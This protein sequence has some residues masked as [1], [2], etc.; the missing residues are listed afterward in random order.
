MRKS[1]LSFSVFLIFL[2]SGA[3]LGQEQI[4]AT[5][6][7]LATHGFEE[8]KGQVRYQDPMYNQE[9]RYILRDKGLTLFFHKQG[10]TYQWQSVEFEEGPGPF[11]HAK[12]KVRKPKST[13]TYRVDQIWESSSTSTE[14]I[15]E[16]PLAG[17]TL[18]NQE[19]GTLKASHYSK[20]VYHNIYPN[21]DIEYYIKDNR[22]KYDVVVK[23]GAD[24]NLV[25]FHYEGGVDPTLVNGKIRIETPLGYLEEQQPVTY[26]KSGR[27]LSSQYSRQNEHFGFSVPEGNQELAYTIDPDLIWGTYYGGTLEEITSDVVV[28]ASGNVYLAGTTGSNT[29]IAISGHQTTYNGAYDAY[30]VKFNSAGVRQWGTY[31]GGTGEEAAY[32]LSVDGTGNIYLSGYTNSASGISQTGGHQTI[33]GGGYDAF[34]VKFNTSGTRVWATYYGGTADDFPFN[35]TCDASG[36]VYVA[37]RASSTTAIASGGHQNT[38]GGLADAFLVKFNSSGVRQFATYYGGTGDDYGLDCE[39]DASG[40][41]FLSGQTFSTNAIST[42]GSHQTA[43]GGNRDGFLVKFNSA[44]VRQF[45]TYYGGTGADFLYAS[46]LDPGGNIIISG[47]TESTTG[48]ASGGHQITLLGTYDAFVVKFNTSG[49]RQ[50]GTY[51]GNTGSDFAA[52]YRCIATDVNSNIFL[53]G[54]TTSTTGI[55]SGGSFTTLAGGSDSYLVKFNAAGVRQ[56]ATY[57]GGTLDETA[58]AVFTD[59]SAD[60][61]YTSGYTYSTSGIASNG[62]QSTL[63]GDADG[64]LA[65][66]RGTALPIPTITSFTPTSGATGTTVTITGTNFST[67]ASN[68]IVYFGATKATVTGATA[69]SLTVTVPVGATYRPITVTVGSLTAYSRQS[70][71]PTFSGSG[72]IDATTLAPKVDFATGTY[73]DYVSLADVDIDGKADILTSNGNGSSFSA[74][75][76]VGTSGSMTASS[77]SPKVDFTAATSPNS[78]EYGDLDGDGKLDMVVTNATTGSISLYR[79]TST[80]GAITTGSFTAKVDF[81]T[82]LNNPRNIAIRDFDG[83]GKPDIAISNGNSANAAVFRNTTTAGNFSSGSLTG[84]TLFTTGTAPSGIISGDVDGDGKFDL[85]ISNSTSNTISVLRN[86][87]TVG[88]ISFATKVDFATNTGPHNLAMADIDG[89]GKDDVIVPNSVGNISVLR[90]S[91]TVGTISLAAKVDFTAGSNTI[92][93]AVG[94]LNGDGKPDV[95][96][97]NTTSNNISVFRNTATSGVISASSLASKIDFITGTAPSY[98]LAVGDLDGDGKPDVVV[99]NSGASANTVSVF[100]NTASTAT[101][102]PTA[103]PTNFT[104]SAIT[105]SS[106]TVSFTAAAGPPAGYIAIRKIGSAPTTDPVDG[107]AYTAGNPLGDGTIAFIGSGVTFNESGLSA[108]TQYFYKIYSYNGSGSGINYRI[109]TP[110]QGNVTTSAPPAATAN[111]ALSSVT[112]SFTSDFN[113]VRFV[114]A[115]TAYAVGSNGLAIRTTDA[116]ASWSTLTTGTTLT[117]WNVFFSN[118]TTGYVV[119]SDGLAMKTTNSGSSWTTMTTGTV[120]DLYAISF[121]S[122]NIGYMA[123]EAGTIIKTT[124]AGSSWTTLNSGVTGTYL[125]SI[126]FLDVNTGLASGPNGIIRTTDGGTTW[127]TVST[128]K[129]LWLTFPT[130]TTGYGVGEAGAVVKTTNGGVSWTTLFSN[131]TER[132]WGA[133]F[134]STDVGFAVGENGTAIKTSNGGTSWSNFTTDLANSEILLAIHFGTVTEGIA[135]GEAGTILQ[136]IAEAPPI[137]ISATNFKTEIP[138]DGNTQVS[139]TIPSADVSRVDE[140]SVY[141]WGIRDYAAGIFTNGDVETA[142]LNGSTYTA[143]IQESGDDPLGYIYFFEVTY[144]GFNRYEYTDYGYAYLKYETGKTL[145]MPSL[146]SGNAAND[147]QLISIPL[148]LTSPQVGSVFDELGPVDKKK[149][150]MF[151]YQNGNTTE[152]T[153]GSSLTPGKGYWLITTTNPPIDIGVGRTVTATDANPFEITLTAGWNLIGNPYNFSVTWNQGAAV[154]DLRQFNSGTYGS[155]TTLQPFVGYF[156]FADIPGSYA[157]PITGAFTGGRTRSSPFNQSE[158]SWHLPITL[159]RGDLRNELGGIGMH[160]EATEGFDSFDE[161]ALPIPAMQNMFAMMF[162]RPDLPYALNK[163]VVPPAANHEW[164]FTIDQPVGTETVELIWDPQLLTNLTNRV[165]LFDE[166]N[167]ELIDMTVKS[168]HL[169]QANSKISIFY[170]DELFL[171]NRLAEKDTRIAQPYPNPAT[172]QIHIPVIVTETG[173]IRIT[174]RDSFGR[175]VYQTTHHVDRGHHKIEM[176]NLADLPAGLYLVTTEV[177]GSTSHSKTSKL[178]INQNAK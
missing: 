135:V 54:N 114:N 116:G 141:I 14:I 128:E 118:A 109:A 173:N 122:D 66:F 129:I 113:G 171:Q 51:Y 75:R 98:G 175:E 94:D 34:L 156:V 143:T 45:G 73:P 159:Q 44:G 65:K 95:I 136:T 71:M 79:N 28:D 77:F 16:Q 3:V 47:D 174:I 48:I 162:D 161:P 33:I 158:N 126:V 120:N 137:T 7:N 88:S 123:G 9:V 80:V 139:I 50:W 125:N 133:H 87:S 83:D 10:I 30:L 1:L 8:N 74:L 176:T 40:N 62:H 57:Y 146:K 85:V 152:L 18:V 97:S 20:I 178:V 91:S 89:D 22:L 78:I 151:S 46:A 93:V 76:N 132:L 90:N 144:D 55:A 56:W 21:I 39:V 147:Y 35:N 37:G 38:N 64:F 6:F 72:T 127:T 11:T 130:A 121:P 23:P 108:S 53:S 163:E 5:T 96:S 27:K 112:N 81:F 170:G 102:E 58:S 140:V 19:T 17:V 12:G 69:T 63:G 166:S 150:R 165:Y 84:P 26:S 43:Y 61:V 149:W 131:T 31:Y 142:T 86:T 124:N 101:T 154:R 82:S 105:T 107:T 24:V 117:L 148:V 29:G 36:N 4:P 41:I 104:S 155:S 100:R 67:T 2:V 157:I 164:N 177:Q 115:T 167:L 169:S 106:F 52:E 32:G 42:T 99:P 68:N 13:S 49:V 145:N 160:Q 25:R 60:F 168:N 92:G 153:A 15:A 172:S 138:K 119:G 103:Q 70:F 110:L 111:L 134:T 59:P